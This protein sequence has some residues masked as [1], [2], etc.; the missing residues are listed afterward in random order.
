V[1]RQGS[2]RDR[3]RI[4]I[5]GVK[6]EIDG[7][8]FPCKRV[9]GDELVVEADIF[10][11]GHEALSAR[12]LSR[13]E[14]ER[15]WREAVM[16]FLGNDR[17]RASFALEKQGRYRYTLEA[18]LDPFKGWRRD[19]QKRLSAYQDVSVDLVIGGQLVEQA[20]ERASGREARALAGV[21]RQA[22]DPSMDA[23]DRIRLMMDAELDELMAR[24]PDLE[25]AT[26]YDLELEV[27]VE[28]VRARFS[29]WYELFP[30]STAPE[31]GRHGTFA[32]VERRLDYV[33]ELGFDTLYLPPIHPIGRERRKGPN[34]RET[35]E[36]ATL[37]APGPSAP[38][39]AATRRCTRSSAHWTTSG[40][41]SRR[42][43]GATSRS[44]STSRSRSRRTTRT[45][46]STRSGSGPGRTAPSSTRRTRRRST[47]TSTRSTSRRATGRRSGTSW[48][49]YSSSGSSRASARSAWT[50]R[51]R[52]RS[53]SG[54]GAS[55]GSRRATRRGAAL[56]GV[57]HAAPHGTAGQAR[58]HAVV[59]LLRL[60]QHEAELMDYMH[61]LTRT[62]VVEYFRPNFWPN[63]PDILTEYLQ[64][65]GRGAFMNRLVLAATLTA[66]YGIYGPAFEL[67]EH[68]PRE[69]GSEEYLD[70][71]KYQ[72]RQRD[73]DRPDSLRH[74]IARVNRI[75]RENAALHDNR[76]LRF[77][78]VQHDG[79]ES[80]HIIAYSKST[81]AAPVTPT[82][83]ALYKYEASSR[84]RRR[85]PQ[86]HRGRRQHG[87]V[88][89][90]R[91]LAAPAA[92]ELGLARTCRTWPTTCS[93]M[94]AIRGAASGTTSSSIPTWS[95]HTSSASPRRATEAWQLHACRAPVTSQRRHG[96]ARRPAL[97]QG[98]G[99]LPG[100][101]RAFFDSNGDGM[102]D[103]R[104]LTQKLD[105]LQDLGVTAIWLLPFYPSPWRDDG[106]DI[107]DYAD[108]HPAYGTMADFKRFM[109]EAHGRGLRVITELVIN[110]TSDQHPWF[111]KA[112]TRSRARPPATSTSGRTTRTKYREARIIFKDFES[113]NWSW[114]PVAKQY[115][116]HRFYSHQPDLNFD[117]P[118]S[119]TRC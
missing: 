42:R 91:R 53:A 48:P 1:A 28:P 13:F 44:P 79:A 72:I 64:T 88:R 113:S 5:E 27:L 97:V 66:S 99:H 73:L 69:P 90:P 15:R 41:W 96:A 6:P 75:R 10:T 110:H 19:M 3:R 50:T 115:F 105:Y 38:R 80:E 47:R 30:R 65:G 43:A 93:A 33:E 74:F 83:R 101:V 78:S 35:A 25:H 16:D 20:A 92:A 112:R 22:L 77:H 116:W 108:I 36:P 24:H 111:Q 68:V 45:C 87:P 56:R 81:A 40:D 84:R 34:N 71:E 59:H 17:W 21:A 63:T 61:E 23:T 102:G 18:W 104:G 76:T 95:P 52:S 57:H 107:A 89:A 86:P 103:F 119:M 70:S 58:L 109:R 9:V 49:A 37:A 2:G 60:A 98:R 14:R 85:R 117:N 11:D 32:D 100:H 54:S 39:R 29:A 94:R 106:Y 118:R 67:M 114:D 12:L 55:T 4:I 8:R 31:P 26:R 46:G 7:G 62:D 82:G 51:T